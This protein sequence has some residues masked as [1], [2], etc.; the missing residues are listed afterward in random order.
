MV[1]LPLEI[2]CLHLRLGI[3]PARRRT[4]RQGSRQT[5]HL[6]GRELDVEGCQILVDAV[7]PLGAGYWHDV[8]SLRQ[9]PGESNLSRRTALVL[10]QAF[11]GRYQVEIVRKI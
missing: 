2:D 3:T 9:Q 7:G 8:V 4:R 1:V 10:G 6:V 11:E 5:R